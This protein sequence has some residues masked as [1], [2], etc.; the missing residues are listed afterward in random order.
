MLG[1]TNALTRAV[2][3]VD[4]SG[5]AVVGD[6]RAGKTF[7]NTN[8]N[9]KLT[10]TIPDYTGASTVS[11]NGTLP[12]AG[13]YM[14]DELVVAVDGGDNPIIAENVTAM[15]D[16]LTDDNLGKIVEYTG[17]SQSTYE[18]NRLY[19]IKSDSGSTQA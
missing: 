14:T 4:L 12:T 11:E 7:Y 9:A 2:P 5:N 18:E 13:T 1:R 8:A 19:R 16:L 15:G 10:G 6:V 17:T 3:V